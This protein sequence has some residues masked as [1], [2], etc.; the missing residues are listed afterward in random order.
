MCILFLLQLYPTC[1]AQAVLLVLLKAFPDSVKQFR[2]QQFLQE[3]TDLASEWITGTAHVPPL[4]PVRPHPHDHTHTLFLY[5]TTH[6][7]I[8][9]CCHSLPPTGV[10]SRPESWRTWPLKELGLG[11]LLSD[12]VGKIGSSDGSR[13]MKEKDCEAAPSEHRTNEV[14]YSCSAGPW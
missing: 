2:E 10:K 11:V 4:P 9:A 6:I 1:L 14:L 5:M 7:A 13:L 8:Y 3:L 12:V